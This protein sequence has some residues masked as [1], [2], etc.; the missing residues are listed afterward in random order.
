MPV[1]RRGET[2]D[3][4]QIGLGG[5]SLDGPFVLPDRELG[6]LLDGRALRSPSEVGWHRDLPPRARERV[7]VF[8][9]VPEGAVALGP[10]RVAR[11][12]RRGEGFRWLLTFEPPLDEALWRGL[13]EVASRP[14]P[15]APEE[16]MAALSPA[17]TTADRLAALR[18]F[19][20]RWWGPVEPATDPLAAARWVRCVQDRVVPPEV[21]DGRRL[22][23]VENQGVCL[24]G[25]GDGD[26]PPVEVRLERRD[27]SLVWERECD[28]LSG[29]LLG[30]A[31]HEAVMGAPS[32]ARNDDLDRRGLARLER[33]LPRLP[34]EG[35]QASRVSFHGAEGVVGFVRPEGDLREA[36]IG[37]IEQ[38]R[39]DA[40]GS[41]LDGWPD[42]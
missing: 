4:R 28:T 5:A 18:T 17:S 24:W 40:L 29:F 23:V 12:G 21:V 33:R 39:I 7:A 15:P 19:A 42:V 13:V 10:A 38:T 2:L 37:A 26:D 1:T 3:L 31:L 32:G 16:A 25:V 20:E 8:A 11:R 30:F 22:V 36:W 35:W 34:I 14:L 27:G 6:L 9:R 41:A